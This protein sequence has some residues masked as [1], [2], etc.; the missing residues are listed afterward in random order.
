MVTASDGRD[1]DSAFFHVEVKNTPPVLNAIA[2]Q[3]MTIGVNSINVPLTATDAEFD[4]I[5]FTATVLDTANLAYVYDQELDFRLN[6]SYMYNSVGQGE[7]W[8]LSQTENK[9]YIILPDGELYKWTGSNFGQATYVTVFDASYNADPS[10]LFDV[11][12]PAA[13]TDV[14]TS[15]SGSMLTIDRIPAFMGD[16]EILVTA[17]DGVFTVEQS[18]TLTGN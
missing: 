18:F 4:P 15:I 16:I 12:Q 6:G 1:S 2:N 13:F 5:S 14:T 17:S 8:I 9:W 3:T 10:L 11:S 7:R